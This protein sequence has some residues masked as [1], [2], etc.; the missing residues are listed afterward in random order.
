MAGLEQLMA[1]E[2]LGHAHAQAGKSPGGGDGGDQEGGSSWGRAK[3]LKAKL[4]PR[5][6]VWGLNQGRGS[7]SSRLKGVQGPGA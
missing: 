3:G 7:Q 5:K 4:G 2:K 1:W 6:L